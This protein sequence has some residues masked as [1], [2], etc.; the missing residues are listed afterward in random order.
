MYGFCK[1]R[2]FIFLPVYVLL[3]VLTDLGNIVTIDIETNYFFYIRLFKG[4]EAGLS[5]TAYVLFVLGLV[6]VTGAK[7]L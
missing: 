5:E 2:V 6:C 1:F 3:Y 4:G 7:S